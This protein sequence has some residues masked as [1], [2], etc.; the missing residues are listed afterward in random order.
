MISRELKQSKSHQKKK[1]KNVKRENNFYNELL[2]NPRDSTLSH[3]HEAKNRG[4]RLLFEVGVTL[5]TT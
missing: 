2:F 3:D 4:K 5:T 1:K